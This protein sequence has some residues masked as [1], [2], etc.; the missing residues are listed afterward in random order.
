MA[1][2]CVPILLM[3]Q[4]VISAM[5]KK[6]KEKKKV[7]CQV[8]KIGKFPSFSAILIFFHRVDSVKRIMQPKGKHGRLWNTTPVK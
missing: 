2:V 6:K 7:E 5:G 1:G 8:S 4:A 3:G